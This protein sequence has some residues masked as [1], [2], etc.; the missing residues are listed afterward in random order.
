MPIIS[1]TMFWRLFAALLFLMLI[2][3]SNFSLALTS[4][5]LERYIDRTIKSLENV[6]GFYVNNVDKVNLD[7][8]YGLRVGQG[9]IA[10]ILLH[11]NHRFHKLKSLHN[12]MKN[13]AE[14][15][16]PYLKEY[17]RNYFNMFKPIVEKPWKLFSGF[18]QVKNMALTFSTKSN[19]KSKHFTQHFTEKIS[20]KCMTEMTG[21][22]AHSHNPCKVSLDCLK[23]MTS[24]E[25]RGY[26]NTHQILYFLVG[27][28]TGCRHIIEKEFQKFHGYLKQNHIFNVDDFFEKKCAQI[29]VEMKKLSKNV[30]MGYNTDL[31][32][33]Q[34]LVCAI[35]GFENFLDPTTLENIFIWQD[36]ELGCFGRMKTNSQTLMQLNYSR[37][38]Q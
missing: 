12:V 1:L 16:L 33:E 14:K 27:L 26:G 24:N 21:T 7:S 13:T 8:I 37:E 2:M 17:Q 30:V 28:Q 25:L 9:A 10:S 11:D 15:S 32:M 6:V 4:H 34:G 22:S 35:L 29:F 36:K 31:F 3:L 19:A 18:R 5:K 23:L 20:D 38:S